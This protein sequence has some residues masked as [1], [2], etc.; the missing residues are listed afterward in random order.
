MRLIPC[1]VAA[2][3]IAGPAFAALAPQYYEEAR[4]NAPEI[5]V[6]RVERVEEPG[7]FRD[8]GDCTV[9]GK[10]SAVERGRAY[11]VGSPARITVPCMR[12]GAN[13]PAGG[14][15]W[16]NMARLKAAKSGRAFMTEPGRL[17]L[18][19]YDILP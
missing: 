10:I 6:V 16:Q 1:I 4:R 8:H 19:Q 12:P 7:L 11:R 13:I 17:A 18:Y 2:A 14:T 5:V 9:I 15:Q 3:A